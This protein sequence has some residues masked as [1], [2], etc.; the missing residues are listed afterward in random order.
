VSDVGALLRRFRLR[1]DLSQE[2]LAERAGLSAAAVGGLEL[3]SQERPGSRPGHSGVAARRARARFVLLE[4]NFFDDRWQTAFWGP[5]YARL[6]AVK[7][8]GFT[9]LR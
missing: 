8:D 7:H 5:N 3:S 4:S 1:A 6:R 2:A 9:R